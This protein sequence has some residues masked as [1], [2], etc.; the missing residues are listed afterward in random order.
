M[1][2]K[3]VV[4]YV[5]DTLTT[6][7]AEKSLLEI[8]S[9]LSGFTPVICTV[10]SKNADL[11]PE[12]KRL[13]I[14]LVELNVKGKFWWLEGMIKLKKL[15][16]TLRPSVV[17]ATLFKA[18]IIS[19]LSITSGCV[20]IG[21]FVNDSYGSERYRGVNLSMRFKLKVVQWIDRITAKRVDHFMSITESIVVT[22]GK[23]LNIPAQKITVIYRGRDLQKS[24][25]TDQ[26]SIDKIRAQYKGPLFLTVARL[27]KRKGYAE[28][29]KAFSAVVPRFPTAKYL[30]A[31]EGH[32][33]E[34]LVGLIKQLGLEGK[35]VLLGTRND[36][37]A[38][39]TASDYFVFP[40]HYEG[41]GGA[42]VEAMLSSKPIIAT[43]IPVISE[44][45]EHNVSARLFELRNADALHREMIW[46]LEH[47][48]E[49][50]ALGLAAREEAI[51]RFNIETMVRQHEQMYDRAFQSVRNKSH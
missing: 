11:K 26:R 15:V 23:A 17:H 25:G 24:S 32:D 8:A 51:S 4:L 19:R 41:Q 14:S 27:L 16:A 5:I 9:R 2:D 44:Q 42:L 33:R 35:V 1:M 18:E 3:P 40:S 22:N 38:L 39:L 50:L 49:S 12:V 45:V 47:P 37:P 29:I 36:V 6:G 31:G 34:E 21:S 46:M 48:D 20:L 43:N 10:F 13:G 30:I 28:S 7:G